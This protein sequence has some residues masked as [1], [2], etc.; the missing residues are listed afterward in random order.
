VFG[1]DYAH[2]RAKRFNKTDEELAFSLANHDKGR[3]N[4]GLPV[5]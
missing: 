2:I 3:R 1:H 4:F 5:S